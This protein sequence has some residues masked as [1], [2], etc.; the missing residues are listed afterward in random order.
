[1]RVKVL[2]EFI[3]HFNILVI[4]VITVSSLSLTFQHQLRQGWLSVTFGVATVLTLTILHCQHFSFYR[5]GNCIS[6]KTSI[7]FGFLNYMSM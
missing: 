7:T 3:K 2:Y 4:P 1:M 6:F 5:F